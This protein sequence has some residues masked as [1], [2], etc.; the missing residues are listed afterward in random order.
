MKVD[1]IKI[2]CTI[3]FTL[4]AGC[5]SNQINIKTFNFAVLFLAAPRR[6]S[7]VSSQKKTA[8]NADIEDVLSWRFSC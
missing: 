8:L 4:N 6:S 2:V 3:M 5:Q 1:K 7:Q